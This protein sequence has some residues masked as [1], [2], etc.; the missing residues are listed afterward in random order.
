MANY[1]PMPPDAECIG[2]AGQSH[3]C[4][5][6]GEE[7]WYLVVDQH[8]TRKYACGLM[9]ELGSWDAVYADPRYVRDVRAAFDEWAD[10]ERWPDCGDWWPKRNLCC[11]VN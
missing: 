9:M 2:G 10:P 6:N 3:W 1:I 11:G 4:W 8:P 7:C 5:I